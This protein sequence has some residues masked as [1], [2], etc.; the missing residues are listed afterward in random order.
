MR[1]ARLALFVFVSTVSVNGEAIL[2]TA[3]APCTAVR[4]LVRLPGIPEASGVAASRRT[5]DVV[6]VLNDSGEPVVTALNAD[7]SVLGRVRLEG[8]EIVDWEDIALARCGERSC[9]YV[10][11]IGDNKQSRDRITIYRATEPAPGDASAAAE[12]FSG[13]YPDGAHDAEA[14]FVTPDGSMFVITK[15]DA[16]PIALYRFPRDARA[17]AL[18]RLERV[19]PVL[20]ARVDREDRPTGADLSPDGQWVA[21]RTTSRITFYRTADLT[22]GRWNEAFRFDLRSLGEP[23]GE[24]IAFGPSGAVYV[25]GEGGGKSRGGTFGRLACTLPR[26]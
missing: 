11:D 17:G 10:G 1:H 14:L 21:V 18:S 7:G 6:W 9:L 20:A 26:Q 25:A 12:A 22:A 24:G 23:Q 3:T 16:G 8:A 15:G 5:T 19:G 4:E 13:V 2:S